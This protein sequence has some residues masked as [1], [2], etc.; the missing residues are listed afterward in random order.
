MQAKRILAAHLQLSACDQQL[1]VRYYRLTRL[2]DDLT[3]GRLDGSYQ[4]SFNHWRK[5]HCL[6]LDDWGME[7]L[8]Q[9]HAGQLL[10]VLEDRYQNRHNRHQ[11]TTCKVGTT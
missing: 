3:A 8:P 11:S 1:T 2:F 10:E 7:K 4:N 6:I 9:E 5:K